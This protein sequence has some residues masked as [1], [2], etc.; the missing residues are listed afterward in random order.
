[1]LDVEGGLLLV[2]HAENST[3]FMWS[4]KFFTLDEKETPSFHEKNK[5]SLRA[6]ILRNSSNVRAGTRVKLLKTMYTH[7]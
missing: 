1:M 2:K 3:L 5:H 7:T 4:C 6:E